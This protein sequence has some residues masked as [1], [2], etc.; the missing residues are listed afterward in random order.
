M[1]DPSV[2]IRDQSIAVLRKAAA[3]LNDARQRELAES[4]DALANEV[5]QPCI[6][7]IVGRMKA[8]KSSFLNALLKDDL[9]KVGVNETTATINRFVYGNPDPE[10]PVR[11]H[12]RDGRVTSESRAF[13]DCLQ[14]SDSETIQRAME[15]QYLEYALPNEMLRETVLVDTPGMCTTVDEHKERTAEFLQLAR[16]LGNEHTKRT[17]ELGSQADARYLPRRRGWQA[18][19]PGIPGGVSRGNGRAFQ[20]DQCG[21]RNGQNRPATG[22][23]GSPMGAKQEDCSTIIGLS[24]HSRTSIRRTSTRA[25]SYGSGGASITCHIRLST[26]TYS[27]GSFS[28]DAVER[29]VLSNI[30]T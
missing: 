22:V 16:Q 15:I 8:G 11:C 26:A 13:L 3:R 21:G 2:H 23:D 25:G 18:N 30:G 14:G 6:I 7:A 4:L 28:K 27:S 17:Q 1:N 29:R 19:R 24:E 9:A 10:R 20:P 5:D 12:W